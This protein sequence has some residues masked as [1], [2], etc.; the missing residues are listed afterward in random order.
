M[1]RAAALSALSVAVHKHEMFTENNL[2]LAKALHI[3]LQVPDAKLLCP[4]LHLARWLAAHTPEDAPH[5]QDLMQLVL[6]LAVERRGELAPDACEEAQAAAIALAT[7]QRTSM[8][9]ASVVEAV[10]QPPPVCARP[11]VYETIA[12]ALLESRVAQSSPAVLPLLQHWFETV[13]AA[14]MLSAAT[15]EKWSKELKA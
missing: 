15:Q 5:L 2:V 1:D 6:H 9:F 13:T 3:A 4:A 11:E 8:P 7:R 14:N 12:A 10:L